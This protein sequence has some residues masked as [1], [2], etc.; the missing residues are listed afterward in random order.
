MIV[1]GSRQHYD[2]LYS[3]LVDNESWKTLVEEAH[4]SGCTLPDWNG[5][6]MLTV[7]CGQVKE[8]TNG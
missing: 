8:L 1:I 5:K 6:N 4:D 7:C 2:D 3:H